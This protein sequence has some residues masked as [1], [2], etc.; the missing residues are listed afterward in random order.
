M[1][2]KQ[3]CTNCDILAQTIRRTFTYA[4]P[5]LRERKVIEGV[6]DFQKSINDICN[7]RICKR[8]V[9]PPI[10]GGL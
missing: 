8:T 10:Q 2:E 9:L 1:R 5:E 7:I 6:S 3:E 4:S